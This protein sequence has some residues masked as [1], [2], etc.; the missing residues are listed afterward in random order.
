MILSPAGGSEV[1]PGVFWSSVILK[2]IN[3]LKPLLSS[4]RS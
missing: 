4:S 3:M 2:S 1:G